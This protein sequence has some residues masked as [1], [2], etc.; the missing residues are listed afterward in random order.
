[1]IE[2]GKYKVYLF[3]N[4]VTTSSGFPLVYDWLDLYDDAFVFRLTNKPCIFEDGNDLNSMK[5][6][7]TSSIRE[8]ECVVIPLLGD[9]ELS[10]D[11]WC[12]YAFE[13]ATEYGIPIIV[14]IDKRD[15]FTD[16]LIKE[17]SITEFVKFDREK[18]V[19][20]VINACKK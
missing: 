13:K 8:S 9:R 12:K 1:M 3:E 7:I 2:A 10:F 19:S 11:E 4:P 20:S 14:I 18:V 16:S 15:S 17:Y 6:K 5:S